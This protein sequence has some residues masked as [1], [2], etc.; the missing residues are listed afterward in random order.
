MVP[1]LQYK[2][3]NNLLS[4]LYPK[5]ILF[6]EIITMFGTIKLTHQYINMYKHM[7]LNVINFS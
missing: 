6:I 1:D 5:G 2:W 3:M 4:Y 7:A